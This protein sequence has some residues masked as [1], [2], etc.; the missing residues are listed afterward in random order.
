MNYTITQLLK[1]HGHCASS[2]QGQGR[3]A[4]DV[5][6]AP[7]KLHPSGAAGPMSFTGMT[8]LKAVR[9]AL[10]EMDETGVYRET[11]GC[12]GDGVRARRS[13]WRLRTGQ[14]GR[15]RPRWC[16]RGREGRTHERKVKRRTS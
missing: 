9:V 7:R 16:R 14:G 2:V 3:K 13:G 5:V 4:D 12:C 6:P 1:E 11:P 8:G 10:A 15:R